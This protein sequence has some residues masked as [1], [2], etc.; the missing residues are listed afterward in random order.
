MMLPII[1]TRIERFFIS[2]GRRELQLGYEL[3]I[4]RET[5][6]SPADLQEFSQ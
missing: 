4:L 3:I 6:A 1:M 2:L 5:S